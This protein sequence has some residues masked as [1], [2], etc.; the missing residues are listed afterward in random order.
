MPLNPMELKGL[1]DSTPNVSVLLNLDGYY[2]ER[3]LPKEGLDSEVIYDCPRGQV[4]IRTAVKGTQIGGHFHAVCDEVVIVV[5][6]RGEILI[7]GEWKPVKKGDIHVCPRG[8][9]H[10]T[11]ALD[12]NLQYISIFTPHLPPGTDINWIK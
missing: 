11:R 4:M 7:N 8:I 9:V 2:A 1:I 12:E 5:G 6:G 10:D 3:S